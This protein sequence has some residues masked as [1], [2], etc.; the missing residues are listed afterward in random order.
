MAPNP[1][2]RVSLLCLTGLLAALPSRDLEAQ[3]LGSISGTI[4]AAGRGGV[5]LEGARILIVGTDFRVNSNSNGE[6]AFHGLVPGKYVIQ[7]AA[8]GYATLLAPIEVKPLE[9][10]E[11]IF[12]AQPE[13]VTLPTLEV[14]QPVRG[15][16]DFLRRRASGRG[17][18][19]TRQDIEKRNPG[20]IADLMRMVPGIRVECRGIVCRVYSVR[21]SRNCGPAYFMDGI[22]TDPAAVWMTP[23][24]DLE[25]IEIYSGPSETPPELEFGA[26][27]GAIVLWTRLPPDRQPK[28][29]KPDT[30][31]ARPSR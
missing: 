17:R 16:A 31:S 5:R 25:A 6:F 26:S 28:E 13:A 21:S 9:M 19:F 30:T 18:Y 20:S 3:R 10:V 11:I 14:H 24:R 29:R 7:A 22:P 27:C 2:I 15:T 23:P 12:E 4:R 1:F 8:I